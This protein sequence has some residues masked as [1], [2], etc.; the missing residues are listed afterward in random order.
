[1][2]FSTTW[3]VRNW[4]TPVTGHGTS[5]VRVVTFSPTTFSVSRTNNAPGLDLTAI[6]GK[7][8]LC[9]GWKWSIQYNILI[10]CV[11]LFDSNKMSNESLSTSK[12][13]GKIPT[14]FIFFI[15]YSIHFFSIQ[16]R[17]TNSPENVINS[18]ILMRSDGDERK[19]AAFG[20]LNR[21][22]KTVI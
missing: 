1:M 3:T 12:L 8:I 4:G 19:I 10:I 6:R 17:F 5:S 14:F 11:W 2:V 7:T 22:N 16:K 13:N 21:I 15:F 20:S 18:H 9:R